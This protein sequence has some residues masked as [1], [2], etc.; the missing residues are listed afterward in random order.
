MLQRN[1]LRVIAGALWLVLVATAFLVAPAYAQGPEGASNTLVSNDGKT[2]QSKPTA[3]RFSP[4]YRG[5]GTPRPAVTAA[6][7]RGGK[8]RDYTISSVIGG[9]DRTPVGKYARF[10]SRAI[11]SITMRFSDGEYL[12]TA[13]F[14]GPR[15]L[16]TA[17]HCVYDPYLNEWAE[18]IRVFPGRNDETLPYGKA[19]SVQLFTSQCW[20]DT[21]SPDC[22][23]GA[24]KINRDL[25]ESV[26]WFGFGWNKDTALL[27]QP[28]N[29]RGYPGDKNPYGVM[30]TMGG[31]LEQLTLN[32]V[33][34]SIDTFGGQSG[35]PVYGKFNYK[36]GKCAPCAF[37]I[38]AYAVNVY[39]F[40]GKNSGTR[41]TQSVFQ[42]L[43]TWREQ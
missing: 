34:Y 9:D 33:G 43:M 16:A 8:L 11:A 24:I 17:G 25:G 23:Y 26:G 41:I 28:V 10:P 42:D 6:N 5:S 20:I 35:S 12:C 29:V 27:D 15:T 40:I 37:G 7:E 13:W 30:W 19:R 22:D 36:E 31:L 3:L 38:H 14:I 21:E 18:I 32:R 1:V 4:S 2:F 39:P